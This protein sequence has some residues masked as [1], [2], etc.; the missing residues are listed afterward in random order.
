MN[1]VDEKVSIVQASPLLFGTHLRTSKDSR[2]GPFVCAFSFLDLPI[3]QRWFPFVPVV[4]GSCLPRE[5]TSH[6][7]KYSIAADTTAEKPT[8]LQ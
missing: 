5:G 8:N 7:P 3:C 4:I 6:D 2:I 1:W